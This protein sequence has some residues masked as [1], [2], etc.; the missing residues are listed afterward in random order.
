[1]D[2]ANGTKTALITD[3]SGAVAV[4]YDMKEKYIY[5]ADMKE[6]KIKKRRFNGTC[7]STCILSFS[8][9]IRLVVFYI[10]PMKI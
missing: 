9:V 4:A 2:L 10:S 1:M 7:K 5:W 8:N 6:H 3:L